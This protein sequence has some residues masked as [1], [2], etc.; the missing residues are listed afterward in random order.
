MKGIRGKSSAWRRC[1]GGD[2][3]LPA[4]PFH[5]DEGVIPLSVFE[6]LVEPVPS[7]WDSLVFRIAACKD[8]DTSTASATAL[9]IRRTA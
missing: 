3:S 2:D 1:A 6:G 8:F 7:F 5:V 4:R 9:V